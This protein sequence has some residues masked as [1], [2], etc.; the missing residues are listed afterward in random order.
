MKGMIYKGYAA[1][2]EFDGEDEIFTGRIVG[3]NDVVGFHAEDVASLKAAFHEAVDDY[4]EACAKAGKKP[5]RPYSGSLMVRVDP[6][7]HAKVAKAAEIMGKSLAQYAEE[8]L[9]QAAERD[10]A[11]MA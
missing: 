11:A 7:V 3:I 8:R 2:V 1:A 5:D 10:M 9:D 4:V 6:A